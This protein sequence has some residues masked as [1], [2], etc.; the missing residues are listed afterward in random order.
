MTRSPTTCAATTQ[1]FYESAVLQHPSPQTLYKL[2]RNAGIKAPKLPI[3]F[4]WMRMAK[5]GS[6]KLKVSEV[7]KFR[8]NKLVSQNLWKLWK[9]WNIQRWSEMHLK[10]VQHRLQNS[11]QPLFLHVTAFICLRLCYSANVLGPR[12]QLK[13]I[14]MGSGFPKSTSWHWTKRSSYRCLN[15]L[16]RLSQT[17]LYRFKQI[18]WT[19]KK[20]KKKTPQNWC[21]GALVPCSTVLYSASLYFFRTL[22]VDSLVPGRDEDCLLSPGSIVHC[23]NG[24]NITVE[25]RLSSTPHPWHSNRCNCLLFAR[26]HRL[27]FASWYSWIERHFSDCTCYT[28]HGTPQEHTLQSNHWF[29]IFEVWGFQTIWGMALVPE[30]CSML[31]YVVSPFSPGVSMAGA[32]LRLEPLEPGLPLPLDHEQGRFNLDGANTTKKTKQQ[33]T[34]Y[35]CSY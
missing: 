28:N 7:S 12:S 14:S 26:W 31:Q 9:V 5:V 17:T 22:L 4:C 16:T 29:P 1:F 2:Q 13:D 24:S 27:L 25:N 19:S 21:F 23:Q 20:E 30:K 8:I 35:Y 11:P 34:S 18:L 6:E 32:P 15:G 10:S 33:N 3:F